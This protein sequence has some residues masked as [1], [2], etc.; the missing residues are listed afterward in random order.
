MTI[1]VAF[2]LAGTRQFAVLSYEEFVLLKER[3]QDME[4]LLQLRRAKKIEDWK[5]SLPLASVKRKLGL[6]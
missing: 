6:G 4:D 5:R 3:L 2:C 1:P